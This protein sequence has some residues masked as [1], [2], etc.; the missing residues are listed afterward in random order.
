MQVPLSVLESV[1]GKESAPKRNQ[2]QATGESWGGG[3]PRF[4]ALELL[5][6]PSDLEQDLLDL[7]DLFRIGHSRVLVVLLI[8]LVFMGMLSAVMT[9]VSIVVM[10]R[11]LVMSLGSSRDIAL[12]SERGLN[13]THCLLPNLRQTLSTMSSR[14]PRN[15]LVKLLECLHGLLIQRSR[16]VLNARDTFLELA[17][18]EL[19]RYVEGFGDTCDLFEVAGELK[20]IL[21][22]VEGEDDVVCDPQSH[23]AEDLGDGDLGRV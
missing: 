7:L 4:V 20:G 19:I 1:L 16:G 14:H 18:L 12:N 9:L 3:L 2:L 8:V 17:K 22:D 11:A 15:Q 23:Q 13:K 10:R 5:V 6:D 21:A